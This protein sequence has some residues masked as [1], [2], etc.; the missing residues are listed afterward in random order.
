M[1]ERFDTDQCISRARDATEDFVFSEGGYTRDKSVRET[2]GSWTT[3]TKAASQAANAGASTIRVR[4]GWANQAKA[5]LGK[6][7]LG[8]A[9]QSRK[10]ASTERAIAR[11]AQEPARGQFRAQSNGPSPQWRT[12]SSTV[13]PS[14]DEPVD[15]PQ[16]LGWRAWTMHVHRP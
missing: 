10:S 13:P 11:I 9:G 15:P 3:E 5:R 12:R 8:K 1:V 16:G 7:R 14:C 6:A 2:S 4:Q